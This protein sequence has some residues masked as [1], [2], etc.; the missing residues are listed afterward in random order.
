[1]RKQE[2]ELRKAEA[3]ART[4][5]FEAEVAKV[6]AAAEAAKAESEAAAAALRTKAEVD[7][8][9]ARAAAEA[10]KAESEAA[11]AESE[12]A[13]AESEAAAAALRTKAEV[14]AAKAR[15]AAEDA[16]AAAEAAKAAAEA[17]AAAQRTKAEVD[18]AKA[19]AAA[20]AARARRAEAEADAAALDAAARKSAGETLFGRLAEHTSAAMATIIAAIVA[21]FGLLV[22]FALSHLRDSAQ[23]AGQAE[24]MRRFERRRIDAIKERICS[25]LPVA[26]AAA[27]VESY[28]FPRPE[29]LKALE[30]MSTKAGLYMVVGPKGEGKT[31]LVSQFVSS[32]PHVLYANL[33][34]GS[35]DSAVRAVAEALGYDM[36]DSK[37]EAS[38]R[39]RGY[40]LPDLLSPQSRD[41]YEALLKAFAGACLELRSERKLVPGFSPV[42]VLDHAN[43]PLRHSSSVPPSS[44]P[45]ALDAPAPAAAAAAASP[46]ANLMYSTVEIGHGFANESIA[47][48]VMVSSDLLQELDAWRTAGGR[49]SVRYIRVAPFSDADA[50]NL[51]SRRI[52]ASRGESETRQPTPEDLAAIQREYSSTISTITLAL[53]TRARWLVQSLQHLA[54]APLADA[55]VAACGV[56]IPAH[57]HP[58]LPMALRDSSIRVDPGVWVALQSVIAARKA[59]VRALLNVSEDFVIDPSEPDSARF[60]RRVLAVDAALRALLLAPIEHSDLVSRFFASAEHVL[61]RLAEQHVIFYNHDTKNVEMESPLVHRVVAALLAS[62]EHELSVQLVQ[63]LLAWQAAAAGEARLEQQVVAAERRS[64]FKPTARTEALECELDGARRELKLLLKGIDSSRV[65]LRQLRR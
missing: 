62:K 45:P 55:A 64:G 52:F 60:A 8:A 31:A 17:A 12:A 32:H 30:Y 61:R 42:L 3:E 51:L 16:K 21:F 53:G 56:P 39:Q 10:A 5:E 25:R 59:D 14:D 47:S 28:R 11:K 49:D 15:A 9:K 33:Q 24:A 36:A 20:E 34:E 13:K 18:V 35:M 6:R 54:H 23:A 46:D 7:V 26:S 41:M 57:Y 29:A 65:A 44:A 63:Q 19:R 43:R 37:E 38:A 4:A 2:A 48:L 27:S 50:A 22:T 58:Y 1:M 40:R